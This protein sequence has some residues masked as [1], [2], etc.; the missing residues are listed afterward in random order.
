LPRALAER[1]QLGLVLQRI[2]DPLRNGLRREKV[3]E[4]AV[5]AVAHHLLHRRRARADDKAAGRHGLEHG[6][7]EHERV[8]QVD[9]RR[10]AAEQRQVVRIRDAAH[11]AHA[12]KV[13]PAIELREQPLPVSLAFWQ[14]R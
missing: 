1:L 8:R 2:G 13:D 11:E 14:A 3:D 10:R 4:Q 7:G 12:R 9:V 5:L 6:P